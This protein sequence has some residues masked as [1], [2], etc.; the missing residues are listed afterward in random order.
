MSDTQIVNE[1]SRIRRAL[2]RIA[3]HV[4]PDG[5]PE[6]KPEGERKKSTVTIL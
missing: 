3:D 2:E 6:P 5:K 4:D 1:L